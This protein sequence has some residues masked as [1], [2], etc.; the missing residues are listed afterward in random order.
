MVS[1]FDLFSIG[2]GPSSSHTV[3]PM[4]AARRFALL[5]EE[6]GDLKKTERV[7]VTLYGSLALTGRGH[8]TLGAIMMG[9]MGETPESVDPALVEP[10][11]QE[12]E[13]TGYMALLGKQRIPFTLDNI[14]LNRKEVL[15]YHSNGMRYQAFDQQGHLLFENIQYSVGGGFIEDENEFKTDAPIDTTP[16]PYPF[17]NA[18]QL[19]ALCE[20]EQ[21]T[22]A[23][24]M[25]K[26][27][28]YLR[29][30]ADV[31]AGI[32]KIWGVMSDSIER[33]M[34]APTRP[35]PG[36]LNIPRRARQLLERMK[37]SGKPT[38]MDWLSVYAIAVNEENASGKRIVTAPTNGAAGIIPAVL[39]YY[40]THHESSEE[41]I[42]DY[43][44]TSV[45]I[46]SLYKRNA[47]ISAAEV[48]CQGE[49]GV[50]CSMAAAGL[51][52]IMKGSLYQIEN[53]AEMGME[54]HLGLTCDPIAGL[55]QIPCIERNAMGA[56]QAVNCAR[57]AVMGDGIHFVSLDQVIQTMMNTGRDL[58]VKYKETSTGG[59]AVTQ[60]AC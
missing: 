2:I 17:L 44:L 43:L 29:S 4:R 60:P 11:T 47:S 54:H 50:A 3:G 32:L 59:L 15:P 10:K 52:A 16:W 49:V 36:G 41:I 23:Q 24:L 56:V 25:M 5:L 40:V 31:R 53:A 34:V 13:K 38:D 57:L 33:G 42:I 6:R 7:D 58:S 18:V 28:C 45:A 37:A 12:I 9:L 35:L 1:I 26:N 8:G 51:T 22:I 48:G 21:M 19:L 27:E 14:V 20:K 39:K 46:G 30:E 55:V